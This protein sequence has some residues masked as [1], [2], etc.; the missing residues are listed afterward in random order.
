MAGGTEKTPN[1][2]QARLEEST[3]KQTIVES[4]EAPRLKGVT[5]A[6]FVKFREDRLVYE[7]RVG[8]KNKEASVEIPLTTYRDSTP[9]A[10]LQLFVIAQW[11]TADNVESISEEQIS[12]CIQERSRVKVGDYDLARI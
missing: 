4:I 7:R 12:S 5:T 8:E 9:K 10:V 11:I 6:D 2:A 1:P 3:V